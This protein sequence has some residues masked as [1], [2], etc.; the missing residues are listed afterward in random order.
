M[1]REGINTRSSES[2]LGNTEHGHGRVEA[3][4]Q[5]D[6]VVLSELCGANSAFDLI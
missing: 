5:S 2:C 1:A 6:M 4:L 3:S